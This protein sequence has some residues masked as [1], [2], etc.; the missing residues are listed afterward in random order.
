MTVGLTRQKGGLPEERVQADKSCVT[1]FPDEGGQLK[2]MITP[3]LQPYNA[4]RR[5]EGAHD[6][7]DVT[8]SKKSLSEI[9]VRSVCES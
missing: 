8:A 6:F 5:T 1:T 7:T 2:Q 4:D 9:K 3:K